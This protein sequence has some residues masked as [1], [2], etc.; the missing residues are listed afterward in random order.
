MTSEEFKTLVCNSP[1]QLT[2]IGEGLN[3]KCYK[4]PSNNEWL[5][6]CATETKKNVLEE[7]LQQLNLLKT[8]K[9]A[10]P[11]LGDCIFPIQ[12][13][14]IQYYA[15]VEQFIEGFEIERIGT[16]FTE[17]N[18]INFGQKIV[19]QICACDDFISAKAMYNHAMS[20]LQILETAFHDDNFQIPDM[21]L[22]FSNA[23]GI[24]YVL[25]P[26]AVGSSENAHDKQKRW[27]QLLLK[28]LDSRDMNR[29]WKRQHDEVVD[30]KEVI[31]L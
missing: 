15:F 13:G 9:I 18:I 20:N 31:K 12:I 21:Q 22:R 29:F 25:D 11:A 14:D 16:A 2:Q 27:I 17:T 19:D 8:C 24:I 1:G 5:V 30:F 6:L 4:I 26:G 23:D 7:E 10:V 3:K 28:S